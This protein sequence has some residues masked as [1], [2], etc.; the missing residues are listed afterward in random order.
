VGQHLGQPHGSVVQQRG[1]AAAGRTDHR[2]AWVAQRLGPIDR[3]G[4]PT[5]AGQ[6]VG[7]G[8]LAK[9]LPHPIH[10]AA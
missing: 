1:L 8:G 10:K 9:Q 2:Q 5:A 7:R 6:L 4:A 3:L